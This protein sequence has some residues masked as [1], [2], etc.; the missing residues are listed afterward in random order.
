MRQTVRVGTGGS[1]LRV[2][3]SHAFGT[4]PLRLTGATVGLSAGGASVRPGTV[5]TLTF[6]GSP[7]PS[8][9]RGARHASDPVRL[10]VKAGDRLSVTLFFNGPSGPATF[11]NVAMETTYRAAGERAQAGRAGPRER[12]GGG[13]ESEE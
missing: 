12:A 5:R 2:R 9:R 1:D 8:I 10:P 13:R 3:L 7:S 11:H 4:A 6:G